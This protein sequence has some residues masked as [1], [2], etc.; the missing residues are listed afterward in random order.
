[1]EFEKEVMKIAKASILKAVGDH[2]S[3]WNRP[4]VKLTEEVIEE[5][6]KELK[7]II[8]Q[9]FKEVV[10]GD[11]FKKQI[12]DEFGRK[13]AKNLVA[14]MSGEVEKAVNVFK[15]DPTLKPKLISAL[16]EII[17]SRG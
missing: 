10:S 17:N 5:N 6:K 16:D 11:F 2:L 1:M 4:L 14:T 9:A 7:E 8:D 13:V 15:Q 3:T 12:K